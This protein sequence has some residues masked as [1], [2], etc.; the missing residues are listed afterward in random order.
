[1]V[2]AI[3]Y[4]NGLAYSAGTSATKKVLFKAMLSNGGSQGKET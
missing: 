4:T 2:L 3:I 1:M